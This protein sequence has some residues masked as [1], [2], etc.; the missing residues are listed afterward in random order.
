MCVP[1]RVLARRGSRSYSASR[2]SF[3]H[4]LVV[5]CPS[6]E[7][8]STYE[9]S[10]P[11]YEQIQKQAMGSAPTAQPRPRSCPQPVVQARAEV[12]RE[13][14]GAGDPP[15]ETAPLLETAAGSWYVRSAGLGWHW[16]GCGVKLGGV[17]PPARGRERRQRGLCCSH[18]TDPQTWSPDSVS[19]HR[20]SQDQNI[21][22]GEIRRKSESAS[23]V[24]CILLLFRFTN[25]NT[26]PHQNKSQVADQTWIEMRCS[27]RVPQTVCHTL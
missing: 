27:V 4:S 26:V 5:P 20:V 21:Y 7:A 2:S 13:L 17:R 24:I 18:S 25:T 16:G 19:A 23:V 8:T 1:R 9:K 12:H 6:Q 22:Q 14:G 3:T 15:P 11:S 10:L